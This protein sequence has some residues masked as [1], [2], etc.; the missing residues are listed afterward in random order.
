MTKYTPASRKKRIYAVLV[1]ICLAAFAFWFII[2]MLGEKKPDGS[3]G[4]KFVLEGI[5]AM[6]LFAALAGY[7][8]IPGFIIGQTLGK[9]LFDIKVISSDEKEDL[10]FKQVFLRHLCD[11]VDFSPLPF[12]VFFVVTNGN[13]NK[14]RVG[15]LLGKT[16]VVD[17]KKQK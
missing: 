3:G 1:D 12:F 8:L 10:K 11:P 16:I 7:F 4:E 13:N 17:Y 5:P 9:S 14:Q 6:L 2:I 15:D